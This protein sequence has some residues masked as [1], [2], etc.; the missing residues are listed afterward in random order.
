[1][2]VRLSSPYQAFLPCSPVVPR[3]QRDE[4]LASPIRR[5]RLL[6]P[7][8]CV[9]RRIVNLK[10]QIDLDSN[11]C[12]AL[13]LAISQRRTSRIPHLLR[14][15][16][17]APST[18]ASVSPSTLRAVISACLSVS[19]FRALS[20]TLRMALSSH[21]TASL[22]LPH[23]VASLRALA[24]A[25]WW[26]AVFG[27]LDVLSD[28]SET[29]PA[30]TPDSRMLLG[31]AN[32]AIESGSYSDSLRLF[33]WMRNHKIPLGPIAY[34]VMFKS[35]GRAL[36]IV[37]VKRLLTELRQLQTPVDTV[38]LNS[39]VDALV[40]CNDLRTARE[41]LLNETYA[42]TVDTMTYNTVIKGLVRNGQRR[43]AFRLASRM[44]VTGFRPNAV[45]VNTLLSACVAAGD[46]E[47]AWQLLDYYTT[48][49]SKRNICLSP[50]SPPRPHS[51]PL[52]LRESLLSS[53]KVT[54]DRNDGAVSMSH[55]CNENEGNKVN[56]DSQLKSINVTTRKHE[57]S[58]YV[59]SS[60]FLNVTTQQHDNNFI[61]MSE[62]EDIKQLRI[63]MTTL[64]SGLA[65]AGRT[66]EA[67]KLLSDMHAR[68]VKPSSITY[69]SL[70]SAC[71]KQGQVE[72]AMIL[73]STTSTPS[74]NNSVPSCDL[75]IL[76][77]VI[78]GLCHINDVHFVEEA[79][80]II[81][82]M[83][84]QSKPQK[85][86]KEDEQNVKEGEGLVKP[87]VATI[88]ILLDGLVRFG[89]FD[90]AE[91]YMGLMHKY[92][93]SPTVSSYTTLMKGYADAKQFGNAKRVFREMSRRKLDPDRV[94]LNAFVAVCARSGDAE[95]GEKILKF[96]ERRGKELSPT[97]QSYS[98]ILMLFARE[99]KN[100]LLWKLYDRMRQQG[101]PVNDYIMEVL[102]EYIVKSAASAA[103]NNQAFLENLAQ[104]AGSLL[105]DGLNDGVS[106]KF[107]RVGKRM[108]TASFSNSLCRQ[109]FGGLDSDEF[110]SASEAIFERH[111]WNDIESGW[112][113]F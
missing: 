68:G 59:K 55:I 20:A 40:R 72:Q 66:H 77:A 60:D 49:R 54:D 26:R 85:R 63:A 35:H 34:S 108:L 27:I 106:P 6:P 105:R 3:L 12:D 65:K 70:I 48:P 57:D 37:A 111:G 58:D 43:D 109:Y 86:S 44:Q 28:L 93:I 46:F 36:N 90:R 8:A 69:A 61:E 29:R 16:L 5:L 83:L 1:M 22:R 88:N 42:R 107:L 11:V 110:R 78:T 32:V 23:L 102:C 45:T 39:A 31:L 9:N 75:H 87:A 97:A 25:G 89:L 74:C 13:R 38:L 51:I 41:M 14:T 53:K 84:Q 56:I 101:V 82:Y 81:E 47:T 80:D 95:A 33:R 7:N 98:P 18:A 71:F 103:P 94:A 104:R 100:D 62:E 112:R 64:L 76:N 96:M 73:F 92:R 99:E 17:S 2:T 24:T 91:Y 30:L 50:P 79:A 52:E 10:S 113:F 21:L 19:D 4:R 67:L 15:A